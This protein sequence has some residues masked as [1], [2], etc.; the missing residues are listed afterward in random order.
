MFLLRH[1][2]ADPQ[3]IFDRG[4]A[5]L[6]KP[7]ATAK[8]R[9]VGGSHDAGSVQRVGRVRTGPVRDFRGTILPDLENFFRDFVFLVAIPGHELRE[10]L[11]QPRIRQPFA[12]VFEIEDLL[13]Q[14]RRV[15][16]RGKSQGL[17]IKFEECKLAN[18]L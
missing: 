6:G 8:A 18:K 16:R 4:D 7:V 3:Q 12:L 17:G 11:P 14:R 5:A 1:F 13:P 2:W 15:F 9:G 10:P